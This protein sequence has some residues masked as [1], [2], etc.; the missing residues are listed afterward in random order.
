MFF[1]M[2]Q[3]VKQQIC[4]REESYVRLVGAPRRSVRP[5]TNDYEGYKKLFK[6][7]AIVGASSTALYDIKRHGRSWQIRVASVNQYELIMQI[8][9]KIRYSFNSIYNR[10]IRPYA[11]SV[12]MESWI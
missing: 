4:V 3:R 6:H 8:N 11:T 9:N 7:P 10:P 5:I 2:I 12:N 1:Q